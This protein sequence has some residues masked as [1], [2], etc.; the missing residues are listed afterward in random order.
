MEG[1]AGRMDGKDSKDAMPRF[2]PGVSLAAVPG[3]L[4]S[5]QEAAHVIE[6]ARPTLKETMPAAELAKLLDQYDRFSRDLGHAQELAHALWSASKDNAPARKALADAERI[7][8]DISQR[9]L[10]F[11]LTIKEWP[12]AR[13][14]AYGKAIPKYTRWFDELLQRKRYALP[15]AEERI[16]VLKDSTG[17]QALT[18]IYDLLTGSFHY[19]L[20]IGGETKTLTRAE[21]QR[22]AEHDDR[23]VRKAVAEALV[24]PY[25]EY[26][27]LLGET[28]KALALDYVNE[29][30]ELRG[31]ATPIASRHLANDIPAEAYEALKRSSLKNREVFRRYIDAKRRALGYSDFTRYDFPANVK[32]L[33]NDFPFTTS[34]ERVLTLFKGFAPWMGD[35]AQRIFDAGRVD[36]PPAQGKRDGACCYGVAAGELPLVILNHVDNYDSLSTMA[37]EL[38]H[39][40]HDTLIADL[41]SLVAHP[42][43]V[44]AETASTFAERLLF[45]DVLRTATPQERIALICNHFDAS[46]S[47]IVRQIFITR[48][49]EEAHALLKAGADPEELDALWARLQHE[50]FPT[51]DYPDTLPNWMTIP[52]IH[53]SPYYCYS[54]AFGM[55]LGAALWREREKN[56]AAFPDKLKGILAAGGSVA[57]ADLLK[58][59]DFDITKESFWDAGFEA[60]EKLLEELEGLLAAQ[61]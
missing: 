43:L 22:Y 31:F 38:G 25:V 27:E 23:A 61:E 28:Y 11:A 18:K 44:L 32:G 36:V 15:E 60:L 29:T 50:D 40:V 33:P 3:L 47:T 42:P 20:T 54:Y 21:L 12:D 13:I 6:A 52:H 19:I 10:F 7:G 5:A 58:R 48:F 30:V 34:K 17:D 56:P 24:V 46:I 51:V 16:I 35:A 14:Q 57:T 39:G 8:T 55:L 4:K 37:H 26:R 2:G 53:H 9:I 45:N 41:P 1:K 59:H 49:E